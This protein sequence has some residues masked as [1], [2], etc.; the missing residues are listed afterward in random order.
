MV[1]FTAARSNIEAWLSSYSD[2]R[3]ETRDLFAHRD[4]IPWRW[5]LDGRHR[6]SGRR[7]AV[8]GI[9]IFRL[10]SGRIAEYWGH[11]HR[12][13]MLQQQDATS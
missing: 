6:P 8:E 9:G 1:G 5:Q 12:L 13:G 4:R 3:I 2:H 7:V 10:E 11:Y